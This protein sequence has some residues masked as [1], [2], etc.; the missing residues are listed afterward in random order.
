MSTKHLT[1]AD[2]E[3]GAVQQE[4]QHFHCFVVAL[5]QQ[6][7]DELKLSTKNQHNSAVVL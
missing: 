1:L 2:I 7:N 4:L 5:H 6:I 3:A